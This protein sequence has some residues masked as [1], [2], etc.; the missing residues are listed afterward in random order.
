M[1]LSPGITCQALILASIATLPVAISPASAAAPSSAQSSSMVV[2]TVGKSADNLWPL[3]VS[4]HENGRVTG[5]WTANAK[6]TRAVP[7][8][9]L[10]PHSVAGLMTLARAHR[11]FT[12]PTRI[13]S[14]P[15]N[16]ASRF[17]TIRG[18]SGARTVSGR[19]TIASPGFNQIYAVVLAAAG[20]PCSPARQCGV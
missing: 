8:V 2:I 6:G 12:M 4:I 17:I 7:H 18:N 13:G 11:F 16:A 20:V 3:T 15:A 10:S 9:R 14:G 5:F 19:G 1:K